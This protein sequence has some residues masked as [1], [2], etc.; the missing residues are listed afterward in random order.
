MKI[1]CLQH[2]PFEGPAAI[3]SW[4]VAHGFQVS[5]TRLFANESP[6]ATEPFDLLLIMGGPM[7]VN[8]EEHFDWLCAEKR[9][10]RHSIESG[11]PVLGICL[12][13]QLIASAMGAQVFPIKEREVGW[14]PLQ[15]APDSA[16]HAVF[17][18]LP[19]TFT[20]LHW[21]GE[22]FDLPPEATCLAQ[23]KGCA[24]Q[25]F[26][27]GEW[28]LGM[29]F[30]LESTPGSVEALVQNCPGDLAPGRFVQDS[31]AILSAHNHFRESN[32]LMTALLDQF[33]I[34]P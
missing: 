28:A 11:K 24:H 17:G 32:R 27:I 18:S 10:I 7:S 19:D 25:A 1:V 23:S 8:D 13:A 26:S 22:T 3:G 14:F 9:F 15:R 2:V 12:G 29:Q 21:H 30:H 31:H 34:T 33:L 6:P 4:A 16:G 5:I 20:A